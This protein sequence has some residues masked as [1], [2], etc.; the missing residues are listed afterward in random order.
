[1]KVDLADMD[2][3][4]EGEHQLEIS[5]DELRVLIRVARAARAYM[6]ADKYTEMHEAGVEL[7][8][9]LSDIEDSR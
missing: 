6:A 7:R 9:A 8:A 1:M 3:A 2:P 4:Y 5:S